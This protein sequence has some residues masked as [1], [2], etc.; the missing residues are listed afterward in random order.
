MDSAFAETM[1]Q[2]Y[3]LAEPQIVIGGPMLG[4]EVL[5]GVRVQVA[6]SMLNRHGLIAGAT[7]TGKTKTLQLLAEHFSRHFSV[8]KIGEPVSNAFEKWKI[9]NKEFRENLEWAVVV[10]GDS[11]I[12]PGVSKLLAES[13]LLC[14]LRTRT[15]SSRTLPPPFQ[16]SFRLLYRCTSSIS[17]LQQMYTSI[18]F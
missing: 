17:S 8:V 9:R 6:L 11:E 7:G 18:I 5:P 16:F 2:G 1:T 4:G 10:P 12:S 3:A 13:L 14:V 15:I